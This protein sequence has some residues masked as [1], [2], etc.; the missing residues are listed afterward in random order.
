MTSFSPLNKESTSISVLALFSSPLVPNNS[1][2]GISASGGLLA[3]ANLRLAVIPFSLAMNDNNIIYLVNV[4]QFAYC[5]NQNV[6]NIYVRHISPFLISSS[7]LNSSTIILF[8]STNLIDP[9]MFLN[10]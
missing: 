9:K 2:I 3:S 10:S 8:F 4:Y 1:S 7:F 6:H 5:Y